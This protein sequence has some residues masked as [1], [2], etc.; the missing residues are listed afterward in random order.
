MNL[1]DQ[2]AVM[3]LPNAILF[4]RVLLPLYIF[5]ARYRQMLADCLQGERM[6]AV[7][8]TRDRNASRPYPVASVGLIRTSQLQPDGTSQL[9]L[10]GVSRVQILEYTQLK[11]YRLAR[12]ARLT[13]EPA[14]D[15]SGE[16]L[17]AVVQQFAKA[18]ARAGN[19]LPKTVLNALLTVKDPDHFADLI[20]H[21]L[22]EDCHQK[23]QL[24]QT[25]DV[26]ERLD[27]LQGML[28][29]HIRQF[30]L[31]HQLQG[32]LSNDDVGIN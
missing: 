1:P 17:A 25:L 19:E 6:F 23:Q 3:P 27:R 12:V 18:R 9:I 24:L 8:L 2:V 32:K 16:A 29:D 7:A 31:W 30:K 14:D 20:G 22:L 4:P 5:E 28:E 10:E 15:A 26:L 21:T 13:S 11:P